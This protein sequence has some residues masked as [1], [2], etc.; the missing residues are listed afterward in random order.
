VGVMRKTVELSD[1]NC[2][3]MVID[4]TLDQRFALDYPSELPAS[5]RSLAERAR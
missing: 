2:H 3:L 1:G 4:I 5:D